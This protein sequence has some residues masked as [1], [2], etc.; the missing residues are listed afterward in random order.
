MNFARS[1]PTASSTTSLT[2]HTPR[3]AAVEVEELLMP[4]CK[5]SALASV[6]VLRQF[7]V[8]GHSHNGLSASAVS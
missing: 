4:S 8:G 1:G 3:K 6:W 7:L 2:R 5:A